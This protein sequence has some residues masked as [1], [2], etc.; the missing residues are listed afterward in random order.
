MKRIVVFFPALA[1]AAALLA[2]ASAS[3][4]LRPHRAEY[5]LRLGTALNATRIGS[6][7]QD[8]EQECDGWRIRREL[9]VDMSLTPSLKVK[10]T[11]RT[12]GE[13]QRGTNGFTWRTV[14]VLN[15]TEREVRGTVQRHDGAYRVALETSGEPEQSVLPSLTLMPVAAVSYLVR[16]LAAGSDAFPVLMFGAEAA[17]AVFLIDVKR[18]AAESPEATP[19]SQRHVAVPGTRSWPVTLAFSRAGQQDSK[20]LLSLRGRLFDSGVLDRLVADAG[21]L[22]VAAHLQGLH[23]HDVPTCPK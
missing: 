2:S 21:P 22:T 18:E 7:V 11:S 6:A 8:I 1:A 9:S 3:A 16:R 15:G 5:S 12:G 19:P 13:E 23:M 20:P 14:Q 10:I 4:Q 17:G